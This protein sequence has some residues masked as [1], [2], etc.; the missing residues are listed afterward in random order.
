MIFVVLKTAWYEETWRRST[1]ANILLFLGDSYVVTVPRGAPAGS[2]KCAGARRGI[3]PSSRVGRARSLRDPRPDRRRLQAGHHGLENDISRWRGGPPAAGRTRR[4]D[5][6][7]EARGP[8]SPPGRC[9]AHHARRPPRA[10]GL[11]H[12]TRTSAPTSATSTTTCS[13]PVDTSSAF[14]RPPDERSRREPDGA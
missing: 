4:A 1:W 14:P 6:L 10:R 7:P 11:R 12:I 9:A 5:L 13:G 3:P 8:R 2:R